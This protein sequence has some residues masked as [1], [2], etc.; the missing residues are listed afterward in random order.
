MYLVICRMNYL[1]KNAGDSLLQSSTFPF[2]KRRER[3]Q[4]ERGYKDLSR[5]YHKGI[6]MHY[7]A[8]YN[9]L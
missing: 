9:A 2:G 4:K 5:K 1:N 6:T 8:H 7:N 3:P